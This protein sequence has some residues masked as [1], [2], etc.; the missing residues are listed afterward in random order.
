MTRSH[1]R[2]PALDW[3][4]GVA[5]I[6]VVLFHFLSTS[7]PNILVHAGLAVDF[8][9]SLSGFVVAH[10]YE[11]RLRSSLSVTEFMKLRLIRLYPMLLIGSVIGALG[12]VRAYS[13]GTLLLAELAALALMPTPLA[14]IAEGRAAIA[15]NPPEW[16]LVLELYGNLFYALIAKRLSNQWLLVIIVVSA[17]LY[18]LAFGL[19]GPGGFGY[20]WPTAL[21]GIPR[22]S[23]SFCLGIGVYRLFI[24]GIIPPAV[25]MAVSTV[26]LVAVFLLPCPPSLEW[27]FSSLVV[28]V[29]FPLII[30][31]S[32]S[33]KVGRLL[34]VSIIMGELSYPLYI[35]QGG[36]VP[37]ARAL[38]LRV[39]HGG[40]FSLTVVVAS[41]V[42]YAVVAFVIWKQ[43]D[44]PLRRWLSLLMRPPPRT[45]TNLYRRPYVE[46]VALPWI[47]V[48]AP[49][50]SAAVQLSKFKRT[51]CG[52]DG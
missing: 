12:Y 49:E 52:I 30:A 3:L 28:I 35:L 37:H 8:F 29:I 23:L 47:D 42:A 46:I 5:A 15:A 10:A 34:P 32:L 43:V 36:I 31:S 1:Q 45:E 16:T 50:L 2:F 9:F 51:H 44:V 26:C 20:S 38:A 6:A 21:G 7:N 13:P 18:E 11:N 22:F 19:Y 41:T 40:I 4:R 25:P 14:S 39:G 24:A 27:A 48:G 17:A 33:L